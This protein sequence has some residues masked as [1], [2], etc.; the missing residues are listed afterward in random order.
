MAEPG[1][2]CSRNERV[3]IEAGEGGDARFEL[4]GVDD[5]R[6]RQMPGTTGGEDLDAALAGLP[7]DRPCVL[8]AHDPGTFKRASGM[9]IDF[10]LSGH[11][12]GGQIWPFEYMVRLATPSWQASTGAAMR[13]STSA[14]GRASGARRCGWARRT[15]SPRSPCAAARK[16]RTHD[17]VERAARDD[18]RCGPALHRRGARAP[19]RGARARRSAALRHP[20]Q[21]LLDLRYGR[22][23]PLPLREADRGREVGRGEEGAQGRWRPPP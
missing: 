6:S 2:T 21:A 11:T 16:E 23:G 22:D 20:P 8:L 4:A 5:H 19:R 12:H 1:C 9:G 7:A 17:R 15:R 14:A 3:T 13:G 10:Q 18:P